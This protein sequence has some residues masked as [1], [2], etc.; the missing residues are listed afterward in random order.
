[1]TPTTPN[2]AARLCARLDRVGS[3]LCIGLDPFAD[4]IPPLFGPRGS[5]M[6]ARGFCEAVIEATAPLAA[7]FKPQAGLF[8]PWGADGAAALAAVCAAGADTGVPV[9]LDAKRGDIGSTAEGY[10]EA[11]IGAGQAFRADCVTVN[12]YMGL[13]TL[14]PFVARAVAHGR[15][16]AVLVRTSNPGAGDFQDLD[17]GGQPLWARVAAALAPIEARLLDAGAGWSSLMV[18]CGATAPSQAQLLRDLLPHALFLVP[19]FGAQG[20]SAQQA[21]AALRRDSAGGPRGGVVNASRSVL[22]P[23]GA[24]EAASHTEWAQHVH[25]AA[26]AAAD[27]LA[28]AL[29]SPPQG[30]G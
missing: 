18:V 7:A 29:P 17:T 12:P 14:E 15:G 8:E 28:A 6:A 22:Y 24:F 9:I 25:I 23:D 30:A 21:V 27:A 16:V 19:G 10:A 4:R 5:V 11:A 13:D 20:A 2:F 3:P 26:R 1:M